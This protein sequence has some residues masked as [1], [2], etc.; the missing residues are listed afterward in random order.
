MHNYDRKFV[1]II[2][3]SVCGSNEWFRQRI[4]AWWHN[5]MIRDIGQLILSSFSNVETVSRVLPCTYPASYRAIHS[6]RQ[7]VSATEVTTT[8]C[9]G[10][11]R[12]LNF[13]YGRTFLPYA[14]WS[15]TGRKW[16]FE[17][18]PATMLVCWPAAAADGLLSTVPGPT[19][20][21]TACAS[22]SLRRRIK[23]NSKISDFGVLQPFN[24]SQ[25]DKSYPSKI[26]QSVRG[27]ISIPIKY[28]TTNIVKSKLCSGF[29]SIFT[30]TIM[31]FI[32]YYFTVIFVLVV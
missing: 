24:V 25:L 30:S 1:A 29:F 4:V 20:R 32:I 6:P 14:Q 21:Q 17:E 10:N 28:L 26:L 31:W 2:I 15:R 8:L 16:R 22:W 5:G 13:K 3:W 11:M 12:C 27:F 9:A 18:T 7:L 23:H 19:T